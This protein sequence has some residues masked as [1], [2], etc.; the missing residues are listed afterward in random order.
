MNLQ[1]VL[2]DVYFPELKAYILDHTGLSYYSDKNEDLAARISGRIEYLHVGGCRQYL[3]L[4]RSRTA[5]EQ[6]MECLI[7]E[8]TIGETYFFRQVEHFDL[9]RTTIIPA[10]LEQNIESRRIRILS[11]G[12]ATGEEPYSIAIQLERYFADR[13]YGWDATVLASDINPEFLARAKSARYTEWSFRTTPPEIRAEYFTREGAA[14]SVK[15]EYR[16]RV[17]FQRFNLAATDP[18]FMPRD[19]FDVIFCRNVMIYFSKELIARTAARFWDALR[20]GG[21]LIVGHAEFNPV[22]FGKF[23]RVSV[24]DASVYRKPHPDCA[25]AAGEAPQNAAFWDPASWLERHAPERKPRR[26]PMPAA[27]PIA[28]TAPP[29][30]AS[31]EPSPK[32]RELRDLA[33]R[34]SWQAATALGHKLTESEPLNAVAHFTFGLILESASALDEAESALRRAIYLNRSFVLA[35]YHLATCLQL[36]GK[37]AQARKSF[38]N[39]LHLLE[40]LPPGQRMEHGDGLTV[41]DLREMAKIHLNLLETRE[42][43]N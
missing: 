40:P 7:G 20:P 23:T 28:T 39:V 18:T 19:T 36:R 29:P 26:A 34:G 3:N 17:T 25:L 2:T 14:W 30:A 4:L 10:L 21:W 12:C 41:A 9:L 27:I 43:A 16:K 32:L 24:G 37:E 42:R 6:E 38:E 8:L 15:P 5:G 1:T 11:V 22:A 31:G 13:L 33:D 35:H